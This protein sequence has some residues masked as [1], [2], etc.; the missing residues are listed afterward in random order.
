MAAN[1]NLKFL[2]CDVLITKCC[3]RLVALPKT[4]LSAVKD[5]DE[6]V[7]LENLEKPLIGVA[8]NAGKA[9]LLADPK[10][11]I[12]T[13]RRSSNIPK[14]LVFLE[15]SDRNICLQIDEIIGLK[16][17]K[18][19]PESPK[20]GFGKK[21]TPLLR[22]KLGRQ[23]LI[24]VKVEEL[25]NSLMGDQNTI[26]KEK[27][28]DF[29]KENTS[30]E[31]NRTFL[32][33]VTEN[34]KFAVDIEDL[35][36]VIPMK[37]IEIIDSFSGCSVPMANFSDSLCPFIGGGNS[38]YAFQAFFSSPLENEEGRHTI[39]IG[40]EKKC[41]LHNVPK[42]KLV[43]TNKHDK[44]KQ[45]KSDLSDLKN[46]FEG[47]SVFGF[48]S[49]NNEHLRVINL[50]GIDALKSLYPFSPKLKNVASGE[51]YETIS[52][53]TIHSD[54][55]NYLL[56]LGLLKKVSHSS[57]IKIS[58]NQHQNMLG[59]TELENRVTAVFD[60]S[61]VLGGSDVSQRNFIIFFEINEIQAALAVPDINRI[62][63]SR[64]LTHKD[65]K[66]DHAAKFQNVSAAKIVY[67]DKIY[68]QIDTA[69]LKERFLE[70]S[71]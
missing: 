49:K 71:K 56:P 9:V 55:Y 61:V 58:K 52:F 2:D 16:T 21:L 14:F 37:D 30:I 35:N 50:E 46:L 48:D 39:A 36:R 3:D 40:S 10:F 65:I 70:L 7:L 23:N 38:K 51:I 53:L 6:I 15:E 33:F 57:E 13:K 42:N 27:P 4:F 62:S 19:E 1:R 64:N 47:S 69:D 45:K 34:E 60:L 5:F 44:I 12:E 68:Y 18:I 63:I 43:R 54:T 17:I 26:K 41:E 24:Y 31:E 8:Q 29:L 28:V 20:V 22:T 66:G 11:I 25:F 59:Y 67:S 32:S